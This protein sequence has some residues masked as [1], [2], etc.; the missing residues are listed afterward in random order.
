MRDGV[1]FYFLAVQQTKTIWFGWYLLFSEKHVLQGFFTTL[2]KNR[3]PKL[4]QYISFEFW[5]SFLV[6][7]DRQGK[8]IQLHLL[9]LWRGNQK[10]YCKDIAQ[11]YLCMN[12]KCKSCVSVSH[13]F[14]KGQPQIVMPCPWLSYLSG[15]SCQLY[16]L[17]IQWD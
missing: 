10:I 16:L 3:T 2:L 7:L 6:P 4:L 1:Q 11:M 5:F 17:S 15:L 9:W 8:L 13:N 12:A 14:H